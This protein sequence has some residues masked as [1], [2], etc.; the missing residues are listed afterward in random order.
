[1][2]RARSA[3]RKAHPLGVAALVSLLAGLLGRLT[4]LAH[5]ATIVAVV[6]LSFTYWLCLS[7]DDAKSYG[8]SLGGV[9]DRAPIDPARLVEDS[10]KALGWS[11]AVSA[12]VLP[13]FVWGFARWYEPDLDF[14]LARVGAAFDASTGGT[15]LDLCLGH[16]LVI[17]LPEEAFF[18][19]YVQSS[20][21]ERWG[22]PHNLFGAQVG[23]GLVATS[24]VFALGHLLAVPYPA[25][26]AVFFPSLLFGWLRNRTGGVG[27]SILFH[28]TCN[29]LAAVLAAGYGFVTP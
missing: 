24:V 25:R 9:L 20:L 12:I 17:A 29:V 5:G 21:D 15:L 3:L 19:G 10:S 7:G 4:P 27:A 18:R 23:W 1:M 6:F 13:P 14:S 22:T 11:L 26:L 2:N 16:L 8:L 28:G